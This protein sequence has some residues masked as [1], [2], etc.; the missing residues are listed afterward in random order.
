M[1]PKCE[2]LDRSDFHDFYTIKP[3][4]VGDFG[5]EMLTNIFK[6]YFNHM[7]PPP[8]PQRNYMV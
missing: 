6:K 5:A 4:W 2:I 1:V 7:A 8:P 3:F